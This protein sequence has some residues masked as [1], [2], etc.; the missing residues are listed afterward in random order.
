[1][2]LALSPRYVP[3]TITQH[4]LLNILW[5]LKTVCL[6]NIVIHG[7]QENMPATIICVVDL[8]LYNSIEYAATWK[9]VLPRQKNE[10]MWT[11]RCDFSY[12]GGVGWGGGGGGHIKHQ[13]PGLCHP[14]ILSPSLSHVLTGRD[15]HHVATPT[16]PYGNRTRHMH[17]TT[18]LYRLFRDL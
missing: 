17:D 4:H 1:M 10:L 12:D 18:M 7:E 8:A 5:M 16:C 11:R 13:G 6:F 9:H 15:L 3:A 2:V 14:I